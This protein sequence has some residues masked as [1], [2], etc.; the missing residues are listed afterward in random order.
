MEERRQRRRDT[1]RKLKQTHAHTHKIRW[2]PVHVCSCACVCVCVHVY[3][4]GEELSG[5]TV[6]NKH[7]VFFL[8]ADAN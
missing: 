6:L 8:T 7:T 5:T 1:C 4:M 2:M 3:L